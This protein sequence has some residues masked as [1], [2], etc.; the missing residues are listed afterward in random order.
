MYHFPFI[1]HGQKKLDSLDGHLAYTSLCFWVAYKNE[2]FTVDIL[3]KNWMVK[4]E[5]MQITK[6]QKYFHKQTLVQ[7][8]SDPF[9]YFIFLIKFNQL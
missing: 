2:F 3:L 1:I 7:K 4:I 9:F 6:P 5:D 8:S